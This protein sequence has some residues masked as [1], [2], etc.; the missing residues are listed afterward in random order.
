MLAFASR[1]TTA[2][3]ATDWSTPALAVGA[4]L[5]ALTVMVDGVDGMLVVPSLAVSWKVTS[6]L[7]SQSGAVKVGC[8]AFTSLSVTPGPLVCT[9]V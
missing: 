5:L 3:S 9:H 8:A 2:F 6:V 7:A 4:P 1:V